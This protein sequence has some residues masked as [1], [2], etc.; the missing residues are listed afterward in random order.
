MQTKYCTLECCEK[1]MR[2]YGEAGGEVVTVQ[3]GCL[4]LGTVI[5][6][7]LS[8]KN[9]REFVIEEYYINEWSSGHKVKIYT[10]GLPKKYLRMLDDFYASLDFC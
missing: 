3:E 2:D 4:G 8:N 9:L 5:L 7:N 10:K 1:L 6:R